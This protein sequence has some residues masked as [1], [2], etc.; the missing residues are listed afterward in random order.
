MKAD[1]I[2]SAA[3]NADATAAN[4]VEATVQEAASVD[5]EAGATTL[6]AA[7]VRVSAMKDPT[8]GCCHEAVDPLHRGRTVEEN[9]MEAAAV[10]NFSS[11]GRCYGGC[12]R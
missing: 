5:D 12:H 8:G 1:A 2:K 6:E 4:F 9:F 7:T 11:G 10:S 3:A